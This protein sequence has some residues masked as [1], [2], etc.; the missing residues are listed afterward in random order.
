M[1][2]NIDQLPPICPLTANQTRNLSVAGLSNLWLIGRMRLRMAVN[3]AQDKIVNY[4]KHYE[5]FFVIMCH[6]VFNVQPKTT[7]LLPVWPSDAKRLDTPGQDDVP[8]H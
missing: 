8:T 1:R 6:N 7:L 4:L 2:E 3:A 5:I